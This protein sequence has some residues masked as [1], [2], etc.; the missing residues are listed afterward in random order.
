MMKVVWL[1]STS[2]TLHLLKEYTLINN[3]NLKKQTA[4][5][6]R[7]TNRFADCMNEPGNEQREINLYS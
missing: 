5:G 7:L 4:Y 3:K 6:K 1:L 2:W